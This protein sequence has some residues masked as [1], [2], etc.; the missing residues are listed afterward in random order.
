M[1]GKW[2]RKRDPRPTT[3]EGIFRHN[4]LVALSALAQSKEEQ[5]VYVGI[6]CAVCD[7]TEDFETYG[8]RC[9]KEAD[10][11]SEQNKAIIALRAMVN[12]FVNKE[13]ECFDPAVLELDEWKA[14]RVQAEATLNL[15]GVKLTALP[16]PVE[17]EPGVWQTD[18]LGHELTPLSTR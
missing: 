9:Y 5:L 7:L 16:R 2:L 11:T 14:I 8:V 6:G 1:L 10:H 13:Q 15:F 3:D 4:L 17:K 18:V 12:A